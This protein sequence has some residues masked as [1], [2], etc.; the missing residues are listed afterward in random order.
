VYGAY[1]ARERG[2]K[3]LSRDA[4]GA[5]IGVS[6][7]AVGKWERDDTV[8]RL[9]NLERIADALGCL[10]G[11]LLPNSGSSQVDA[12]FQPLQAALAGLH[13]DEMRDFILMMASQARLMRNAILA[14]SGKASAAATSLRNVEVAEGR[15]H[16]EYASSQSYED[17]SG[18]VRG[19]VDL[20]SLGEEEDAPETPSNRT[21]SASRKGRAR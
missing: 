17:A 8:P 5:R 9:E 3:G 12:D 1:I 20:S 21:G 6:G 19:A 11:D 13:P 18:A 7:D 16:R 4:L 14:R 2:R 15:N 10:V